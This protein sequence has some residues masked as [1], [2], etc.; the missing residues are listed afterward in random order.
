[1]KIRKL[2]YR[3]VNVMVL[4]LLALL[5][6]GALVT[7]TPAL[8]TTTEEGAA[9]SMGTRAP[10]DSNAT[11]TGPLFEDIGA[12]LPGVYYGSVAWGDYDNDGDLDILL[13]GRGMTR[14]YRNDGGGVFTNINAALMGLHNTS[15]AWGDYDNDGDLDILL[16]GG[17]LSNDTFTKI[18][19]HDGGSNFTD[20]GAA[21]TDVQNGSVAWG[22]YDN[23]GDLDILLSGYTGL[24][25]ISKIY[26]NDGGAV[27]PTSTPDCRVFITV[28]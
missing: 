3:V 13:T 23:D 28:P 8:S 1:M 18:Y 7:V 4:T 25:G 15:V 16:T 10:Q 11:G 21:L 27:S 9:L 12:G 26:R 19:R 17:N 24:G 6:D 22:D 5:L 14:I 20:I 2:F